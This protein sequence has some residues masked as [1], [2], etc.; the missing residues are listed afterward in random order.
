MV[1]IAA[2]VYIRITEK[3]DRR[4]EEENARIRRKLR[5][6]RFGRIRDSQEN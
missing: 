6:E 2:V 3:R 4:R 5:G 1:I